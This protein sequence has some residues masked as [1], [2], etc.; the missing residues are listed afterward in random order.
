[1]NKEQERFNLNGMFAAYVALMEDIDNNKF[2]SVGELRTE[3]VFKMKL[4]HELMTINEN[5]SI[6]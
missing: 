4:I 2:Q 6:N 3:I 5:Q 1:M